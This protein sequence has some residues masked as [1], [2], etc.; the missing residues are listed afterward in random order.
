MVADLLVI[1]L[2]VASSVLV[3][4]PFFGP[5]DYE[6]CPTIEE[7]HFVEAGGW[8]MFVG[9]DEEGQ[10]ALPPLCFELSQTEKEDLV[11]QI[12]S[13]L[14]PAPHLSPATCD[15]AMSFVR[16]SAAPPAADSGEV[17]G[18]RW[19][20]VKNSVSG[21]LGWHDPEGHHLLVADWYA[22]FDPLGF[23]RLIVHEAAHHGGMTHDGINWPK[24]VEAC[25]NPP[26]ASHDKRPRLAGSRPGR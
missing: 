16:A 17:R 13:L 20:I 14:H 11:A 18:D 5:S 2:F 3:A 21:Q 1:A 25:L 9:E 26:P 24:T 7:T 15:S 12:D 23:L 6:V 4:L 22:G 8:T 19:L 10:E